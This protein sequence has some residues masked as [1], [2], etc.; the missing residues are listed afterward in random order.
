MCQ[1]YVTVY[2][3]DFFFCTFW[4]VLNYF[5][6]NFVFSHCFITACFVCCLFNFI[7][8]NWYIEGSWF[9][10][11][12]WYFMVFTPNLV[13][14]SFF[15]TSLYWSFL[16]IAL[17][18]TCSCVIALSYFNG[19]SRC[20]TPLKMAGEWC[21]FCIMFVHLFLSDSGSLSPSFFSSELDFSSFLVLST[22][23]VCSICILY[24]FVLFSFFPIARSKLWDLS[25]FFLSLQTSWINKLSSISQLK[26]LESLEKILFIKVYIA[27]LSQQVIWNSWLLN[28]LRGVFNKCKIPIRLA[29]LT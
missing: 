16:L 28:I 1:E 13:F 18:H 29:T 11:R 2:L 21:S 14:T 5:R 24:F 3:A 19:I 20:F 7:F 10:Y 6:W 15:F 25:M 23:F 4:C 12:R 26:Y 9:S 17:W 8:P 22:S 27:V